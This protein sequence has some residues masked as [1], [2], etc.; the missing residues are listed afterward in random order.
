[1][2]PR[3]RSCTSS[4]QPSPVTHEGVIRHRAS[5][6]GFEDCRFTSA[7]TPASAHQFQDWLAKKRHGEMAWLERTAAK[8]TEPQKVLAGAKSVIC[9]A[10]SYEISRSRRREEAL[11]EKEA[12]EQSLLTSAPTTGIISSLRPF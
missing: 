6:L 10:A 4:S 9:L 7:V 8:R 12:I 1:M 5:E 11:T 3:N 2:K